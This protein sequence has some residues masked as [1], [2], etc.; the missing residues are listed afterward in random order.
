MK[1][2][3]FE[4]KR[5][6]PKFRRFGVLSLLF[7]ILVLLVTGGCDI[8]PVPTPIPADEEFEDEGFGGATFPEEEEEFS[9]NLGA[10]YEEPKITDDQSGEVDMAPSSGEGD[11]S[12]SGAGGGESAEPITEVG[13]R[14]EGGAAE[15]GDG[16]D[17]AEEEGDEGYEESGGE[18][19]DSGE[20]AEG[21]ESVSEE[22]IEEDAVGGD[23]DT[24]EPS[25]VCGPEEEDA[26][27]TWDG[28]DAGSLENSADAGGC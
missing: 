22:V 15:S 3:A 25:D 23:S 9:G 16:G 7:A 28:P 2:D 4:N 26:G 1:L 5:E 27:S 14:E 24:E 21:D 6:T 19:S 10:G 11:P 17:L 12:N 20:S 13:D 18:S 8:S